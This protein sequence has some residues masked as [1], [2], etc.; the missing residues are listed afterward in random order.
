[1][2]KPGAGAS[3]AVSDKPTRFCMKTKI[4]IHLFIFNFTL[5]LGLINIILR[6]ITILFSL[7]CILVREKYFILGPEAKRIT[8]LA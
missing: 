6:I 5:R 4:T 2:Y 8:D 3:G 7:D 1:M